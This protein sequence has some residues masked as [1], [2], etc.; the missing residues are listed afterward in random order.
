MAKKWPFHIPQWLRDTHA[1]LRAQRVV[2]DIPTQAEFLDHFADQIDERRASGDPLGRSILIWFAGLFD[3]DVNNT[4]GGIEDELAALERAKGFITQPLISDAELAEI[5]LPT[6]LD[7]GGYGKSVDTPH[8]RNEDVEKYIKELERSRDSW[9]ESRN[10]KI[11]KA[12]RAQEKYFSLDPSKMLY[13][14]VQDIPDEY[15]T[16]TL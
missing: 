6:K 16:G 2:G 8:A 10:A 5:G 1:D 7:L 9:V 15:G 12:R 11:E 3:S 14:I 13:E 4:R